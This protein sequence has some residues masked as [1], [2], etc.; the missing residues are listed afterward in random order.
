MKAMSFGVHFQTVLEDQCGFRQQRVMPAESR[1][2][3][4]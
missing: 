4:A 3:V 1:E 2:L